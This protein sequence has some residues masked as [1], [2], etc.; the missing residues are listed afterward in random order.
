MTLPQLYPSA[1]KRHFSNKFGIIVVRGV[2][3]WNVVITELVD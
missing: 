2:R 1:K 3:T